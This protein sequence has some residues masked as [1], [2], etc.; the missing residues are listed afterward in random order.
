MMGLDIIPSSRA[1]CSQ[2]TTNLAPGDALVP[3]K[4]QNQVVVAARGSSSAPAAN[5]EVLL[6]QQ[7][8]E[9]NE[10][11]ERFLLSFEQHVANTAARE[12]VEEELSGRS[13]TETPARSSQKTEHR[14]DA[15]KKPTRLSQQRLRDSARPAACPKSTKEAPRNAAAPAKQRQKRRRKNEYAM[16]L[17][18]KRVRLKNPALLTAAMVNGVDDR[19]D[20]QLQQMAVVKLERSHLLPIRGGSQGHSRQSPDIQVTDNL[21]TSLPMLLTR[22]QILVAT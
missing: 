13:C 1:P 14:N 9:L 21:F 10:M 17:E 4:Q 12:E 7:Q 11:L 15:T 6:L 3:N 19:G 8:G 22:R 18:K 20:K 5:G 2:S 16:S